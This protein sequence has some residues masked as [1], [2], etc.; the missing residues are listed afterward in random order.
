MNDWVAYITA[1]AGRAA[2]K[3]YRNQRES[4]LNGK[5]SCDKKRF[6]ENM[7]KVAALALAAIE[8]HE[9]GYC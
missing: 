8:A 4:E 6:R 2:E 5:D 9:N 1:Y 3:V 7:V